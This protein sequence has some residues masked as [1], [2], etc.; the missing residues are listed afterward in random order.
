[1]ILIGVDKFTKRTTTKVTI[2][3]DYTGNL[4]SAVPGVLE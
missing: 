4:R 2:I 1:M 3:T